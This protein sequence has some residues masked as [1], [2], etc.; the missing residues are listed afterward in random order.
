MNQG[1][2]SFFYVV[3]P[4]QS[5][6]CWWKP[7]L[8]KWVSVLWFNKYICVDLVVPCYQDFRGDT[9]FLKTPVLCAAI[10]AVCWEKPGVWWKTQYRFKSKG[11]DCH[12]Y[13]EVDER[14]H[15]GQVKLD[16]DYHKKVIGKF[17]VTSGLSETFVQKAV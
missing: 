5:L 16:N 10:G 8:N 3:Y 2:I 7:C 6:I 11:P 4:L 13:G 1:T 15:R 14:H 12:F 17:G 9:G